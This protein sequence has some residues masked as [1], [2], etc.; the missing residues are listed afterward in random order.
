MVSAL[1][2]ESLGVWFGLGDAELSVTSVMALVE[3]REAA[4]RV[5][6]EELRVEAERVLAELAEA[7]ALLERRVIATAELAETLAGRE[8]MLEEGAAPVGEAAAVVVADT[9]KAP[10]AGSVVP[11]WYAGATVLALSADYRRIVE[12][13]EAE[14]GAGEGISAKE[15]AG[16]LGLAAVPAKT[17]AVRSKARRLAE[18][19]WVTAL[20]SG[21]FTPRE[22]TVPAR[23]GAG[24]PSGRGGGS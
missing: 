2:R 18:R 21:R 23:A 20:P 16:R 1:L 4:A 8:V 14:P 24:M 7:E 12:L 3:G 22:P 9:A 6:A 17:E 5:R 10:V 15:L 13:V 11:R 19:G